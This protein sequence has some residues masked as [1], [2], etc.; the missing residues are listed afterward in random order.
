MKELKLTITL[1]LFTSCSSTSFNPTEKYFKKVVKS[2]QTQLVT[3]N[4]F[5][6]E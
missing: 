2:K 6:N 5:S 1:I 3:I 4:K